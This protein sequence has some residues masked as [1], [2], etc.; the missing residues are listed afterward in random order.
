[1]HFTGQRPNRKS[2]LCLHIIFCLPFRIVCTCI[3]FF[4]KNSSGF[5][6]SKRANIELSPIEKREVNKNR[7]YNSSSDEGSKDESALWQDDDDDAMEDENCRICGEF[8][9]NNE[10]YS[11]A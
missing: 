7:L 1:M 11:D 2:F 8:G 10:I 3:L 5:G 9:R 4:Q 6:P